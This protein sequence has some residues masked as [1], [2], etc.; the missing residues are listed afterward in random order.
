MMD[1]VV[2]TIAMFEVCLSTR[3]SPIRM[4][5][6]SDPTQS[7]R[8]QKASPARRQTPRHSGVPEV[9]GGTCYCGASGDERR[10]DGLPQAPLVSEKF[11][12]DGGGVRSLRRMK[13]NRIV[14]TGP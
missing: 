14:A 8:T 11:P 1:G 10:G 7:T 3:A 13:R 4:P 2:R 12:H 6:E 9:T 5:K